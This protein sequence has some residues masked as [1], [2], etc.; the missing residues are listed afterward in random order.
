MGNP[1]PTLFEN[2]GA[3]GKGGN[4]TPRCFGD[5]HFYLKLAQDTHY[6]S[7]IGAVFEVSI[8]PSRKNW[9]NKKLWVFFETSLDFV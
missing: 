1:L 3:E 5:F 4:P 7:V 2:L 8:S 9:T 6:E